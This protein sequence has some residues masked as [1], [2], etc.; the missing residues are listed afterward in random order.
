M[1]TIRVQSD[2]QQTKAMV[3]PHPIDDDRF[4]QFHRKPYR[5]KRSATR[6]NATPITTRQALKICNQVYFFKRIFQKYKR[7]WN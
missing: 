6:L 2:F 4:R 5:K 1:F 3:F 7:K